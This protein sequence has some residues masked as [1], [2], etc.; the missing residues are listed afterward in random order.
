MR[1]R[2]TA[3]SSRLLPRWLLPIAV[4]GAL[5]ACSS[6]GSGEETSPT[7]EPGTLSTVD[8]GDATVTDDVT[9][10]AEDPAAT[11]DSATGGADDTG[12]DAPDPGLLAAAELLISAE[13]LPEGWRD[14]DPPGPDFRMEVCGVDTEAVQPRDMAQVRFAETALG[15]FLYQYVRTYDEATQAEDVIADLADALP[16][17]TE[18]TTGGGA[19]GPEA[20]FSVEQ[21]TV[22]ALPANAVAW[23]MT[24][25]N[26]SAIIQDVVFLERG[27]SLVAFLSASLGADP[28]PAVLDAALA[29]VA[30]LP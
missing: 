29:G 7:D 13:D 11:T 24:P 1:H 2:L 26:E 27:Q 3:P 18:F 23:R 6:N 4:V 10:A 17:C 20:T 16:G 22:A 9:D 30:E 14:S 21:I 12:T 15:P 5:T 25:Q 19:Q 28:D 8:T